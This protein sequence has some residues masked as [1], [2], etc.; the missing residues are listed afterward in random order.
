MLKGHIKVSDVEKV[1]EKLLKIKN[2]IQNTGSTLEIGNSLSTVDYL[3]YKPH[4]LLEFSYFYSEIYNYLVNYHFNILASSFVR[5]HTIS[6]V[7]DTEFHCVDYLDDN[8]TFIIKYQKYPDFYN[9]S[10]TKNLFLIDDSWFNIHW[11]TGKTLIHTHGKHIKY[12]C[13][14]YLSVPKNSG[15]FLYKKNQ[16]W[17]SIEIKTGDFLIFP[18]DLL[19]GTEENFSDQQRIT[20]TTNIVLN[21]YAY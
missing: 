12:V 13:T 15:R 11:K 4:K 7:F 1:K 18:G 2:S 19:H 6:K 8:E 20:L 21:E 9:K 17:K 3:D 14:Y 16:E 5:P 10:I